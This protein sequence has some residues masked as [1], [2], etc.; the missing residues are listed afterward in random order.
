[1][2]TLFF[3]SNTEQCASVKRELYVV[4]VV[5]RLQTGISTVFKLKSLK[6]LQRQMQRLYNLAANKSTLSCFYS[7]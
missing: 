2:L 3:M 4:L 6:K 5:A 7:S 1:M